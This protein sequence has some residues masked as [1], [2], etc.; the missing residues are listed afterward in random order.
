MFLQRCRT[1]RQRMVMTFAEGKK[2]KKQPKADVTTSAAGSD[3]PGVVFK[4]SNVYQTTY[5]IKTQAE[6]KVLQKVVEFLVTKTANPMQAYGRNDKPFLAAGHLKTAVPGETLL[7]AHL[8]RDN[9]MVYSI[10][11]RNPT[12][13]KLYGIFNHAEL[14]TGDPANIRKQQAMGDRL[15]NMRFD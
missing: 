1:T 11:G 10:N 14:G 7:H 13:I 15:R 12:V 3:K 6:P 5:N 2:D 8:D 4:R 9:S